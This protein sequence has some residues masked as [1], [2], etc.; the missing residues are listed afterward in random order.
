MR[1]SGEDVQE[2]LPDLQKDE[3]PGEGFEV[4]P[5]KVVYGGSVDQYE[6]KLNTWP[7]ATSRK[8]TEDSVSGQFFEL[9]SERPKG[10]FPVAAA[11]DEVLASAGASSRAVV[12]T[13][14]Q[15]TEALEAGAAAADYSRVQGI[16]DTGRW[17]ATDTGWAVAKGASR[18]DVIVDAAGR[19][20][21]E[22]ITF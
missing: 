21:I 16:L 15:V 17:V 5:G 10:S 9:W 18:I 3:Q 13:A 7:E 19:V 14:E 2:G 8:S 12:T 20:V 1:R 6:Q 4:N 22:R 11:S